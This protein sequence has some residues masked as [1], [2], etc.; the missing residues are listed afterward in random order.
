MPNKF[1]DQ[2]HIAEFLHKIQPF[3]VLETG[4]LHKLARRLEAAYY[5]QGKTIFFSRPAPGLAII[6]KGAVRL[7]DEKH[8]FLDRRSEGEL[9]GHS[10]YFHGELKDYVAE[11]EEDCLLWHL[12]AVDFDRLRMKH[13]LIN[14]YFSSHLNTRLNAAIQI[15]HAVT[16]FVT[17]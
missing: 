5:P 11:A 14:E 1:H 12:S 6:R 9:F 4:E 17:C 15:K 8:K 3:N 10:I 13:A 16:L 7:V 2:S